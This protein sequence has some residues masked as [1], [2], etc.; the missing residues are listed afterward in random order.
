MEEEKLH[1]D[2]QQELHKEQLTIKST[3]VVWLL[4]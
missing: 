1:E 4:N 3:E 2:I